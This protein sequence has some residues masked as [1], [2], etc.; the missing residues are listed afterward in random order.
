MRLTI[1][2]P[3]ALAALALASP[4]ALASDPGASPGPRVPFRPRPWSPPSVRT[5]GMTAGDPA[6]EAG[7][8]GTLGPSRAQALAGVTVEIRP[9]GSRHAVLGGAIRA[10]SVARVDECGRLQLDCVSSEAAATS[11]VRRAAAPG[12][13]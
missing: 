1:V 4:P 2:I 13:N 3:L 9:D 6:V 5:A 7:A 11:R 10:W 8:P 12:G